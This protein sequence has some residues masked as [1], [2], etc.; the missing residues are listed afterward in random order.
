MSRADRLIL[1]RDVD[2]EEHTSGEHTSGEH[3][4][5][6]GNGLIPH[7]HELS[8]RIARSKKKSFWWLAMADTPATKGE[9]EP[10]QDEYVFCPLGSAF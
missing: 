6:E 4:F 2:N 3:G 8:S 5:L 10:C 1:S 7:R 9:Y